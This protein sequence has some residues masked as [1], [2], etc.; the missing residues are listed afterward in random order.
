VPVALDRAVRLEFGAGRTVADGA[1]EIRHYE[2]LARLYGRRL[3]LSRVHGARG[4]SFTDMAEGLLG[5]LGLNEQAV[6]L[7]VLALHGFDC[8]VQKAVGCRIVE[9]VAGRPRVFAVAEQ[10]A[11]TPF[12][13]L[14]LAAALRR[15]GDVDSAAVIAMEQSTAPIV[16]GAVLPGRDRAVGVVLAESGPLTVESVE[17]RPSAEDPRPDSALGWWDLPEAL[18]A[19]RDVE[20]RRYDAALRYQCSLKLTGA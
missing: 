17:V 13:A 16:D 7:I 9:L 2:D 20:L 19:G 15:A 8:G 12:T 1:P 6:D 3:D 18:A 14:K 11:A 4:N 5:P 10:G